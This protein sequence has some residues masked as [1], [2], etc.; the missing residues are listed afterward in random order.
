ML[1]VCVCVCVCVAGGGGTT[2]FKRG[3]KNPPSCSNKSYIHLVS[4]LSTM[5]L[6]KSNY[7]EETE[8]PSA[9]QTS[10][11]I[12]TID[13]EAVIRRAAKTL[14]PRNLHLI[15]I[16]INKEIFSF[17]FFSFQAL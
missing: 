11:P 12:D 14:E 6:L 15:V 5:S 7:L 16:L 8:E 3:K 10:E 4:E 13:T 2:S 17:S 1:C 9:D